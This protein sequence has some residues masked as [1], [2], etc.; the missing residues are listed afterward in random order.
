[1]KIGKH[2]TIVAI[3]ALAFTA[4]V[5][6]KKSPTTYTVTFDA[7][8]RSPNTIQTITEGNKATKHIDPTKDGYNFGYWFNIETDTEWD[9]NTV[10][11]AN[12]TLKA[13]WTTKFEGIW[14]QEDGNYQY[15]FNNNNI[16]VKF[17]GENNV[18]GTF[19]FT[20]TEL[21]LIITHKWVM[22]EWVNYSL[23]S[24]FQYTFIDNNSFIINAQHSKGSQFETWKKLLE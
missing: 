14:T 10:I 8:N 22:D 2:F 13:K 7:D 3:I 9:F 19:T 23:I 21:Q 6:G 12:F 24:I 17:S 20:E 4:C 5:G 16:L 15:I 1:M 18:K 11:T